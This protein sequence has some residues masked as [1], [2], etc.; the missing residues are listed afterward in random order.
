MARRKGIGGTRGSAQLRA[1]G[2][3]ARRKGLGAHDVVCESGSG[4]VNNATLDSERMNASQKTDQT[5][6][7]RVC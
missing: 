4:C 1:R 2:A 3:M 6:V 5:S 7:A